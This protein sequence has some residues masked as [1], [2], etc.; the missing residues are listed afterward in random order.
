MRDRIPD[1]NIWLIFGAIFLLGQ[2]YGVSIS[3]LALFF[4]KAGYNKPQIGTLAAAFAIGIAALALP[5]SSVIKRVSARV[6][7]IA[8]VFGYAVMVT[9]LPYISSFSVLAFARALDGAFSVGVWICCETILLSRAD[10]KNKAFVMSL[11]ANALAL[12]YVF[13]PLL[14]H[15]I[16]ASMPIERAF[17]AAGILAAT[18]GL[19]IALRLDPDLK[20]GAHGTGST[21]STEIV[22]H[23]SAPVGEEPAASVLWKIKTSCFATFSYGY[24]QASVVL[25]L[26]LYLIEVKGIPEAQTLY[27]PAFFAGGM[28][29]FANVAGRLGD[30]HGHLMMMRAMGAIGLT[31]ILGFVFLDAFEA[32]CALVF[33]AGA[34][35]AT[36]SPVSL[37]LSGNVTKPESLAR[38]NGF[39]NAFYAAGMVLGPPISS[40]IYGL[41]GGVAMLLHLAAIWAVFVAFTVVFRRD[42]PKVK[43]ALSTT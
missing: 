6:T 28:L 8:C 41:R 12:G 27:I 38:A 15:K 16:V 39:Y 40:R 33:V 14:S 18:S 26:P 19:L 20:T 22:N 37:A 17:V 32:M 35:L 23:E 43:A 30:R 11:Y 29:L 10:T 21:E 9:S 1:R 5:M 25:F 13:G 24:F 42:D 4:T 36:I 2:A 31:M 7:L 34:T 3:L